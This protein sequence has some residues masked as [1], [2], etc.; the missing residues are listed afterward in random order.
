MRTSRILVAL[1]AAGMLQS[2]GADVIQPLQDLYYENFV[3]FAPLG[4][5]LVPHTAALRNIRSVFSTINRANALAWPS[6][7]IKKLAGVDAWGEWEPK[8]GMEAEV[9]YGWG[10]GQ[11]W[12][13]HV[14]KDDKYLVV[15]DSVIH[16]SYKQ[17][18]GAW[19]GN[20]VDKN[21][22]R[23]ADNQKRKA[24]QAKAPGA[25]DKDPPPAWVLAVMG[26]MGVF[27]IYLSVVTCIKDRQYLKEY[28]ARQKAAEAKQQ[29]AGE[30]TEEAKKG[31]SATSKDTHSAEKEKVKKDE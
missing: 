5:A 1:W 2:A 27:V 28:N 16:S 21:D 4:P 30:S 6:P 7:E 15:A 18:Y 29:E 22:P 17:R 8:P 11:K 9:L 25:S 20:H 24:K 10:T 3:A 12:L 19:W 13:L 23:H 14:P 31:S 26:M